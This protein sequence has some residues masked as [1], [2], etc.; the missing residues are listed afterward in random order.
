MAIVK[1]TLNLCQ[2][3]YTI[4]QVLS[5]T[6]FEKELIYQALSSANLI[7]REDMFSNQP[8]LFD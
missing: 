3:L 5:V 1:E 7:N 4:L 8:N 2:S 6:L